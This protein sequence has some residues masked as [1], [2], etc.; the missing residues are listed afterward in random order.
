MAPPVKCLPYKH[1]DLSSYS[2]VKK[3]YVMVH[4]FNITDSKMDDGDR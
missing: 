4:A 3:P 1:H 2:H